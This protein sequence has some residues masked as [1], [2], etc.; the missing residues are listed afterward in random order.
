[1]EVL[2]VVLSVKKRLFY[3]YTQQVLTGGM[4]LVFSIEKFEEGRCPNSRIHAI[5][6]HLVRTTVLFDGEI[7]GEQT[8]VTSMSYSPSCAYMYL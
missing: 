2:A 3:T 5:Y 6:K 1:M 7:N 8:S 4:H